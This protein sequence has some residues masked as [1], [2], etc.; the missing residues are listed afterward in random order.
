MNSRAVMLGAAVLAASAL[1]AAAADK[2]D[3]DLKKFQGE[4]VAV[5]RVVGGKAEPEDAIKD[6]RITVA[7]NKVTVKKGDK[8]LMA[9]TQKLDPSK[10]PKALDAT[11][12]D[13]PQK[14]VVMLG[15]YTFD[16]DTVKVC[17]DP[18]GKRRPTEFKTAEGSKE[19]L[20]VLKRAAK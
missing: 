8:V 18:D 19:F 13:G 4:W 9:A 17:F 3:A 10:A 16:G 20:D 2:A 7:G 12:T 14:G 1:V 11:M 5:S 6:I 15:I